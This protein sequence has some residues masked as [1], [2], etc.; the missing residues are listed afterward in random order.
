M[1]RHDPSL[2]N[3]DLAPVPQEKRSWGMYNYASLWVAMSVC[4]TRMPRRSTA[5]R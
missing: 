5:F 2:Y 3:E 1:P 4:S